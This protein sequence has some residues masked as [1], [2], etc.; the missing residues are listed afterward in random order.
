MEGRLHGNY[1][2]DPMKQAGIPQISVFPSRG[3]LTHR[4]S[5]AKVKT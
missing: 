5:Q 3:I 1:V 2:K 4:C